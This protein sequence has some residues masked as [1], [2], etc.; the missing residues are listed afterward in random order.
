MRHAMT[1]LFVISVTGA[2]PYGAGGTSPALARVVVRL[3]QNAPMTAFAAADP[4][5]PGSFVATLYVPGQLLVV[6]AAHPD[7]AAIAARLAAGEY[8]DVYLDLQGSPAPEERFFVLD[9]DA[10]GLLALP[11]D[12]GG[13]DVVYDGVAAPLFLNGDYG[14]H[15]RE[16]GAYDAALAMAET[17][18]SHALGVLKG[19]LEMRV[20]SR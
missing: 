13:V 12:K 7:V 5:R 4:D 6:E 1:I 16:V 20:K 17:K 11:A 9:A 18:Y 10:D 8:R 15:R 14:P 2:S 3:L 19:A